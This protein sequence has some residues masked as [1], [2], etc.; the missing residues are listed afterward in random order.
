MSDEADKLW[1]VIV[2][3]IAAAVLSNDIGRAQRW[4]AYALQV[5]PKEDIEQRIAKMLKEHGT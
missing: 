4:Q 2:S 3:N 1:Q 5:L